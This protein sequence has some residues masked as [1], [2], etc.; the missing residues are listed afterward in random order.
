MQ[1][2]SCWAVP[3]CRKGVRQKSWDTMAGILGKTRLSPAVTS[4]RL[5]DWYSVTLGQSTVARKYMIEARSMPQRLAIY[6][7]LETDDEFQKLFAEVTHLL[8][9][10]KMRKKILACLRD[11]LGRPGTRGQQWQ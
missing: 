9:E 8:S 2:K 7:Y 3:H 1:S 5:C 10:W 4:L 11:T 6:V